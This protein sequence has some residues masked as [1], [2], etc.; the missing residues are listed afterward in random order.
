VLSLLLGL[1]LDGRD[2]AVGERR[3][4]GRALANRRRARAS[5][6]D[7]FGTFL[8]LD[9]RGGRSRRSTVEALLTMK[10]GEAN[11]AIYR[12]M[13]WMGAQ[14]APATCNRRLSTVRTT[15]RIARSCGFVV[16]T[17]D[18]PRCREYV[19]HRTHGPAEFTVRR[20]L[21]HIDE[22]A[23]QGDVRAIRDAAL[24]RCLYNLALR[25]AEVAAADRSD[26]RLE[27]PD[28]D[29]AC[30]R[31]IGKGGREEWRGLSGRVSEAI[32]GWLDLRG[33]WG[34]PLFLSLHPERY[35][36]ERLTERGIV[37]VVRRR[38]GEIGARITP[39]GLR[40]T[41]ITVAAEV[42]NGDLRAVQQFSRHARIETVRR[43]VDEIADVG[44]G[45]SA[46]ITERE[47]GDGPTRVDN[48]HYGKFAGAGNDRRHRK[49]GG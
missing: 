7:C 41:A 14:Y 23:R 47:I 1:H 40:H 31:I 32:L 21:A 20:L 24:F 3:R 49:I 34:G 26:F 9:G 18:V 2:Q 25:R 43:Y 10:H 37:E 28:P 39:H 6:L 45:L 5:D 13:G 33:R 12:F 16:W 17:I 29:Q 27:D 46:A 30:L 38:G 22:Q 48:A 8:R 19:V 15:V 42:A 11:E 44:G 35:L 36:A 4:L